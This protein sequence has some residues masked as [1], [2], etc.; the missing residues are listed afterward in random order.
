MSTEKIQRNNDIYARR[1]RDHKSYKDIS[2][3]FGI[4][5][6]RVRQIINQ[7][8]V[9]RKKLPVNQYIP[10]I[11][12]ACIAMNASPTTRGRIYNVLGAYGYLKNNRWKRLDKEDL[13]E[14]RNFGTRCIDILL[15]AQHP[16]KFL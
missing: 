10:E 5:V 16:T 12:Q 1:F 7:V 8:R 3:E 11:E 6:P 13:S 4:T 15:E 14:L 9:N 2:K